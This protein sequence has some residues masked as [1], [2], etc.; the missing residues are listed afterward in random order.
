MGFMEKLHDHPEFTTKYDD[1]VDME[2]RVEV[3][4]DKYVEDLSPRLEANANRLPP[5][6]T[7]TTILNPMFGLKPVIVGS[8]LMTKVQ[9]N[10][11]REDIV[12]T[13]QTELD[14][15]SE[16]VVLATNDAESEDSLDGE[17]VDEE[18]DNRRA[19]EREMSRFEKF[20][21]QRFI[22]KLELGRCLENEDS[23]GRYIKLGIGPVKQR[24]ENLPS[25]NNI[26][27]YID[28]KGRMNLLQF[29]KEHQSSFPN[30]FIIV[31]R[32][33][34]RRVVEVGC[35]RFFGQSGYISNPRRTRLGVKNY[36]RI[37]MLSDLLR[38][39]Y[40]DP[41]LVAKE[42]LSRCKRSA[43]K[44]ENTVDSLKCFNLERMIAA[45]E[46]GKDKPA[47]LEM[48]EYYSAQMDQVDDE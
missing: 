46:D 20:K 38:V 14:S 36:E 12:R 17:F 34:S 19:A 8:T 28:Q 10:Y 43:W 35:E 23:K 21:M 2:A 1:V 45:E 24:G 29:F 48:D 39:M 4:R 9:Y 40:I 42:Y 47:P 15:K 27:D 18:N 31:Q 13:I 5:A 32:E 37:A 33:A 26:A 30:L 3:F 7:R 16:V 6:H 41:E 11:A 25:G 44:K 22:P